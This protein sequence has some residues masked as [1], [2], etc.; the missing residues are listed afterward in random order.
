MNA[1]RQAHK[2]S[3][4]MSY[5]LRHRPEEA[6]LHEDIDSEGYVDTDALVQAMNQRFGTPDLPVAFETIFNIVETNDK[7]RFQFNLDFSR[8][9]ACQGHSIPVQIAYQPVTCVLGALPEHFYHGTADEYTNAITTMGLIPGTRLH[10]H[11]SLDPDTAWNNAKRHLRWRRT[12]VV[13][14]VDSKSLLQH[15]YIPQISENR[16]VLVPH[17]P[18]ACILHKQVRQEL[19]FKEL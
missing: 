18:P 1:S 15:G 13:F 4:H 17:V 5:V 2:I 8:I 16:V 10:V 3:R 19:C 7:H 14:V 12:P 11:L 6:G 9:R